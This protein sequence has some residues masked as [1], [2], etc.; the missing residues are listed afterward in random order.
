[1]RAYIII[2]IK[3][4]EEKVIKG[5]YM[6]FDSIYLQGYCHFGNS[7]LEDSLGNNRKENRISTISAKRFA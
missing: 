1:M 2:C 6:T 7:D 5:G 4:S 3:E